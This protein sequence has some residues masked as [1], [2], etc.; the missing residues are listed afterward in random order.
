METLSGVI[1]W[2]Y[3]SCN[4]SIRPV[5]AEGGGEGALEGGREGEGEERDIYMLVR[6]RAHVRSAEREYLKGD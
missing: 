5:G 6:Q 2:R 1:Y 3:E 4:M